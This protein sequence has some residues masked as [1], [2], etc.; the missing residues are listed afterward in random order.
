MNRQIRMSG[1]YQEMCSGFQ[2]RSHLRNLL[3]SAD[4]SDLMG[5]RC[6]GILV[7]SFMVL[8]RGLRLAASAGSTRGGVGFPTLAEGDHALR[9]YR[10]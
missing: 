10:K 4:V 9:D 3:G 8:E 2:R 1:Q 5:M 7:L 6:G